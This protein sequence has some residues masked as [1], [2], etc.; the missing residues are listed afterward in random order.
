MRG[1]FVARRMAFD[2]PRAATPPPCAMS[3]SGARECLGTPLRYP[4]L[5]PPQIRQGPPIRDSVK[6]TYEEVR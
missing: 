2:H 5:N 4:N 6:S 1:V 3:L